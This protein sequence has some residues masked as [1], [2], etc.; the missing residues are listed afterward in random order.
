MVT[1]FGESAGAMSLSLLSVIPEANVL[2]ENSIMENG[3]Y[4]R[5]K[6]SEESMQN[7]TSVLD[8]IGYSTS[9]CTISD[10]KGL[11]TEELLNFTASFTNLTFDDA[12]FPI[13]PYI[14][15]AEGKISPTDIIISASTY[16]DYTL[17]GFTPEAYINMVDYGISLSDDC[18]ENV[19]DDSFSNSIMIHQVFRKQ[20]QKEAH[21]EVDDVCID[22]R[23]RTKKESQFEIM[24]ANT[25][26]TLVIKLCI[27]D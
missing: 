10:L 23:C 18:E 5:I 14:L 12:F 8:E 20:A 6:T 7:I 24:I 3:N 1:I 27:K 4:G 26:P 15:Y 9:R 16:D 2:F 17:N 25:F 13:D 22:Y 21:T 11:T 19:S